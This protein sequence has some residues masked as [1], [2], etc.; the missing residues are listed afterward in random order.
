MTS[1]PD[2]ALSSADASEPGDMISYFGPF[3]LR[4]SNSR[5]AN[6]RNIS[7]LA[8]NFN[9]KI[10]FDG[11]TNLTKFRLMVRQIPRGSGDGWVISSFCEQMGIHCRKR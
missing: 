6:L 3:T 9:F 2:F 7:R 11:F 5:D 1:W 8:R 10:V 4:S